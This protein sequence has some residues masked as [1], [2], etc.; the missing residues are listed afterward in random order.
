MTE[1]ALNIPIK[2]NIEETLDGYQVTFI[3]GNQTFYLEPLETKKEAKWFKGNLEA[4][5]NKLAKPVSVGKS[6][7][8][9]DLD[10]KTIM[11]KFKVTKHKLK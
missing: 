8:L 10:G 7:Q 4:A 3:I 1:E 2:T 5:F 11:V 6:L 9:C